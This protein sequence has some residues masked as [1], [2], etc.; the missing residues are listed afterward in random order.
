MRCTFIS[1]LTADAARGIG[2]V[3]L[4]FSSGCGG[5]KRC[6]RDEIRSLKLM[7]DEEC[8][9]DLEATNIFRRERESVGGDAA[10][11]VARLTEDAIRPVFTVCWYEL[12]EHLT[13]S[14]DNYRTRNLELAQ[15]C[16][17]YFVRSEVELESMSICGDDDVVYFGDI[18]PMEDAGETVECPTESARSESEAYVGSDVYPSCRVCQYLVSEEFKCASGLGL[19]IPFGGL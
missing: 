10:Q 3:L 11:V 5:H 9:S 18:F 14:S 13:C 15:S 7:P 12:G 6:E 8:P 19:P 4:V 2:L 17:S 16:E 1:S